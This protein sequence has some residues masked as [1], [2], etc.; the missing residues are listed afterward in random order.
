MVFLHFVFY[1][2]DRYEVQN[3]KKRKAVMIGTKLSIKLE[4]KKVTRL[5]LL[6]L[7]LLEILS[8]LLVL[9]IKF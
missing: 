1:C 3:R 4:K 6:L 8:S 5:T 7:V 9:I 2:L